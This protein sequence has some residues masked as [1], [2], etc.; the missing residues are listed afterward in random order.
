MGLPGSGKTTF[1]T[2]LIDILG[3]EKTVHFNADKVRQQFNDWDF[4]VEGR[5]RQAHRMRQLANDAVS[6]GKLAICDFVCPTEEAQE[7]FDDT[8]IIWMDTILI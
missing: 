5:M 1:A 7:L 6:D 8:T 3:A 4:S 2:K